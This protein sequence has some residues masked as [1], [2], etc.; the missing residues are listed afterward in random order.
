M[1]GAAARVSAAHVRQRK[2]DAAL[3]RAVTDQRPR[4]VEDLLYR[5]SSPAARQGVR[6][7]SFWQAA[8]DAILHRKR[9]VSL[10]VTVLLIAAEPLLDDPGASDAYSRAQSLSIVRAAGAR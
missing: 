10:G 9:N 7:P 2:L 8:L 1:F 3:V 6:V 5:G 4:D